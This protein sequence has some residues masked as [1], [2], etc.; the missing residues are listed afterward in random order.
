MESEKSEAGS[1]GLRGSQRNQ[2]V[3]DA[4]R[5]MNSQL[6]LLTQRIGGHLDMRS[7]DFQCLDLIDAHGPL[8]AIALARLA[9][10]HPATMTGII[11]RLERGG[12]IKRERDPDDRRSVILHP[13]RGRRADVLRLT[14]GMSAELAKIC[15]DYTDEELELITGFLHRT[16]EAGRIAIAH[17]DSE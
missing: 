9:G 16:T 4:L 6:S 8:S 7:V 15:A 3:R 5:Q 10:L 1:S 12:W 2:A 13:V 11:D 17:L 14:A